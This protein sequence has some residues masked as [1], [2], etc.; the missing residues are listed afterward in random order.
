ML[1]TM[2]TRKCQLSELFRLDNDV[3]ITLVTFLDNAILTFLF[4]IK[5]NIDQEKS[6]PMLWIYNLSATTF[7]PI[8]LSPV[9]TEGAAD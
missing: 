1:T 8:F 2:K 4:Q 9:A 7:F 3:W 5:K 6:Q